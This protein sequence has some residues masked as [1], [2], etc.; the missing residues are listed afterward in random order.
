MLK[1]KPAKGLQGQCRVP[2]DK[3]I[4]HRALMLGAIARGTTHIQGLLESADCLG[5]LEILKSLGSDIT[6]IGPGEYIVQSVGQDQL[7]EPE[8][9]LDAGNS[10]TTIRLLLGLV[11]TRPHFFVFT[12]DASL[13]RRPMD[14]VVKPLR[15]L[16]AQIDGRQGGMYA[17]IAVKGGPLQPGHIQSP[18]A[19]AQ[20]KSAV[21]LAGLGIPGT[22]TVTEPALSRDHTERMLTYLGC[23]VEREG[24]T[25]GVTG[26]RELEARPI[27]ITGDFSSAAFLLA[28]A[29]LLPDSVVTIENVNLNPTRTGFLEVLRRMGAQVEIANIREVCGEPVGDITA[30][31]SSLQGCEIG[32]DLIPWIIDEL[33]LVALLGSQAQGETLVTDAAELRVKESDRI[34]T[35]AMELGK[36]GLKMET[37]PDG[38]RVQGGQMLQ[39]GQCSSCHDHRIAMMLVVAGLLGREE[40]WI[41][42]PKCIGISFPGFV[43]LLNELCLEQ[44]VESF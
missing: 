12:G 16:G 17:P 5:T 2:G 41:E 32:G 1:V 4:S 15:Q 38:F 42:D 18:V 23:P 35:T 30:R 22:T 28:A 39:G 36:L 34:H 24:T 20:V 31:S 40:T 19:S 14:R 21:L 9:V 10:G 44:C 43:D 37:F 27:T 13:R 26:P 6:R 33:P 29:V 3:S 8:E 11:S 7:R 25:V